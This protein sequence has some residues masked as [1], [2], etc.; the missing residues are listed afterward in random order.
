MKNAMGYVV[1]RGIENDRLNNSVMVYKDSYYD[2]R[3]LNTGQSYY[4]RVEAF[5]ENGISERTEA[6]KVE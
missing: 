5:N 4:F 6:L 3:A 2:L 1:F